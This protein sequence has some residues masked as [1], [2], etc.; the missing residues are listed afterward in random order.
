MMKIGHTQSSSKR[1]SERT[2]FAAIANHATKS[3]R[4]TNGMSTGKTAMHMAKSRLR[5]ANVWTGVTSCSRRQEKMRAN[6][7]LAAELTTLR[8]AHF[9]MPAKENDDLRLKIDVP[10]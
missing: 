7:T 5:I 10:D 2:E 4:S 3:I 1:R 8:F 6:E 9:I